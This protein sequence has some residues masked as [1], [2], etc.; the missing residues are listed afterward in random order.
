MI[1]DLDQQ[2]T[3]DYTLID[4]MRDDTQR[5]VQ[6]PLSEEQI[7]ALD[8]DGYV[9]LPEHIDADR[10]A[11]LLAGVERIRQRVDNNEIQDFE[12]G[13]QFY[14]DL[15]IHD[16]IFES[17]LED[18]LL[19]GAART[20]LGPFVRLRGMT[21]RDN[22]IDT[23]GNEGFGWHAH[24]RVY[25]DP[26]PRWSAPPQA[27]DCLHYLDG[28]NKETGAVAV[29]PGS[30]KQLDLNLPCDQTDY[31]DQVIVELPPRSILLIHTNCYHRSLPAQDTSA[32]RRLIIVSWVPAWYRWSPWD[33]C[34]RS[35]W[36]EKM[37]KRWA[38]D[39]Q[40]LELIGI[41]GYT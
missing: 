5:C 15:M 39:P 41:G 4:G 33:R 31:P 7:D 16:E 26:A 34:D 29:I 1:Q 13:S 11:Q 14:R 25:S 20:M 40:K 12:A 37:S 28:L 3:T 27:L 24:Q 30:H 10:H 8:R 38:D 17:F 9:V 36:L 22:R 21:C 2:V 6:V 18:E 23:G 35:A 19:I 32:R